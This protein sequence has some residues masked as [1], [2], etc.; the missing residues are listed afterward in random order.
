MRRRAV[1]VALL[2]GNLLILVMLLTFVL[3]NPHTTA[4]SKS[5]LG[6]TSQDRAVIN[7][8]DQL[9]SVDI[10]LTVARLNNLPEVTA[11]NN[12]ADS[13]AAEL[14]RALTTNNVVSKPQV[15]TTAL[16]SRSDIQTYK[17][18]AGDNVSSLAAKFGVTSDSI[19]W[20]NNIVGDVIAVGTDLTIP[21]VTG[22][23]YTV[24]AGDTLDSLATK[25]KTNKDQL[26][27][28]NDAEISGIKVGERI[29]MP[30]GTLPTPA[31]T[32]GLAWG[33]SSP[34]FGANNGY[35][36]GYC[37]WYAADRRKEL[38][39]PVPTNLGDGYTWVPR[40]ASLGLPTGTEPRVKAVAMKHSGAPGHVA[41]VEVVNP[42]GSFWISEMNSY[43]QRSM[44]DPTP[45]GGFGIIDW[46][47]IPAS[48]TSAWGFVY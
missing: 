38:G 2:T 18:Q 35:D 17:T 28:F 22:I 37:T 43:G 33:G 32:R 11:I 31:L 46:K 1:R 42:D 36:F 45:M 20:S 24:K 5:I 3:Q 12:Q 27:A 40:A 29:I 13:Q 16:K 26:I 30:N 48:K 41:V 34:I 21:P 15:V 44:T 8:L 7:P 25:Y 4:S 6:N 19:R 14:T 23:V 9:S 47:L 10:A 39:V